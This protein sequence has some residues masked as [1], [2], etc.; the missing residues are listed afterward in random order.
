MFN[1]EDILKIKTFCQEI[2]SKPQAIDA[3]P[4]TRAGDKVWCRDWEIIEI[5]KYLFHGRG[6]YMG[7]PLPN[8]LRN[9]PLW[10]Q[11][12]IACTAEGLI[13]EFQTADAIVAHLRERRASG[14]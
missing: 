2:T 12:D 4:H 8:R 13:K 10:N 7:D 5:C 14:T 11:E 9:N 1:E 3:Q 6:L